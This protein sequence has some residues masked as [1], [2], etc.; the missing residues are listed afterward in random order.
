MDC[1][2]QPLSLSHNG[3]KLGLVSLRKKKKRYNE[4]AAMIL[5]AVGSHTINLNLNTKNSALSTESPDCQYS[6][7]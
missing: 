5:V 1:N 4:T 2:S 6:T 7:T 3:V